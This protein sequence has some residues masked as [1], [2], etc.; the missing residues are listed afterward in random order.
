MTN[1]K[2]MITVIDNAQITL[3]EIDKWIP[4]ELKLGIT[5]TAP[6]SGGHPTGKQTKLTALFVAQCVGAIRTYIDHETTN[7]PDFPLPELGSF[8][9][10]KHHVDITRPVGF[11]FEV[12]ITIDDQATHPYSAEFAG[13]STKSASYSFLTVKSDIPVGDHI[14]AV[15]WRSKEYAGAVM[16]DRTLTVWETVI[17]EP[18]II[19]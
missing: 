18:E 17:S 9:S 19:G 16:E 7:P 4:V 12:R 11:P 15:W 1:V 13:S 3:D 14:V 10:H 5:T 6:E 8:G 2:Q